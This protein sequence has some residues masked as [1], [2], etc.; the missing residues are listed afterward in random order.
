M[1]RCRGRRASHISPRGEHFQEIPVI[2][3]AFRVLGKLIPNM[4]ELIAGHTERM[5]VEYLVECAGTDCPGMAS[6]FI[7]ECLGTRKQ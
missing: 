1:R 7:R 6:V 3:F 4:A 5:L 2:H